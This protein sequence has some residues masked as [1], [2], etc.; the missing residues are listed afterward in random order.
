[1]FAALPF[2]LSQAPWVLIPTI[3]TIYRAL[4]GLSFVGT[5]MIDDALG[6]KMG[7]G[8]A[9][10]QLYSHVATLTA[11]GFGLSSSKC[12]LWPCQRLEYLGMLVDVAKGRLVVPD[13]KIERFLKGVACLQTTWDESLAA[14]MV[15]LLASFQVAF[16][17]TPIL[18]R[19]LYMAVEDG[20]VAADSEFGLPFVQFMCQNI[21]VLNGREWPEVQTEAATK[22]VV[23]DTSEQ[24]YGALVKVSGG[25]RR[26]MSLEFSEVEAACMAAGKYSSTEREVRGCMVALQQ[27]SMARPACLLKGCRVQIRYVYVS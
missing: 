5:F 23:M 16:Q 17:L 12:V 1:M 3:E 9:C 10:W 8:L 27:L 26:K 20:L 15:G 4:R 14:S 7:L 19:T 6:A 21:Q 18:V 24:A 2:G 13:R 11:M 25:A 22:L